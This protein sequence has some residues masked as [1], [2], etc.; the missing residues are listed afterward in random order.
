MHFKN[1]GIPIHI[2]KEVNLKIQWVMWTYRHM[3]AISFNNVFTFFFGWMGVS[4]MCDNYNTSSFIIWVM[5]NVKLT[6]PLG[7]KSKVKERE[8]INLENKQSD[9]F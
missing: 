1:F 3:L 9:T 2:C 7:C 5:N 8:H 4:L 6:M